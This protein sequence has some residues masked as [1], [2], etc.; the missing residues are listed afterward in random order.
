MKHLV[1]KKVMYCVF[2]WIK[3]MYVWLSL[4]CKKSQMSLTVWFLTKL[5]C[6]RYFCSCSCYCFVSKAACIVLIRYSNGRAFYY[7]SSPPPPL[8]TSSFQGRSQDFSKWGGGGG[9]TG[10]NNIVMTFS[11][12][13]IVGCLLKNR[14][15]KGGQGHPR[16]PLATPLPSRFPSWIQLYNHLL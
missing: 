1:T 16:T 2:Y 6:C 5:S 13:N 4:D 7:L 15:T 10:S 3:I 8:A 11:P 12:R 9:H 14:L